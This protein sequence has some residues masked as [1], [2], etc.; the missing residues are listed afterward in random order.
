[1]EWST[2]Q[3][4]LLSHGVRILIIILVSAV[5]YIVLRRLIPLA[6]KHLMKMKGEK[7]DESLEKRTKTLSGIFTASGLLVIIA[8]AAF[9]ILAEVGINIAPYLAAAGI[10]GVA[11]GFGA[12]TLVKDLI[13]GIFIIVEDQYNVGDVVQIAGI[14]GIVQEI[15]LRRTVLRDLDGIVHFVPNGE[16]GIASNYTREWSRVN[17][18]ISVAYDTDLDHA[19]TVINRVC[20][21]MAAEPYW[22]EIILKTPEVLR[23]DNLGDSGIDIKILG[24][25]KPIRQWETMGEIRKRIKKAFDEEGI[26]IPW[27]HTKVYF[28]QTE[29]PHSLTDALAPPRPDF[30]V[31]PPDDEEGE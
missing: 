1:M 26:E 21:E 24:D 20:A 17:L 3:D 22:K 2:V 31:L 16:S 13:G 18:N 15:N 25:T 29:L 10:L 12:Q 5:L 11:L 23:I 27:P 4:W 28:G 30:H 6:M 7:S 9:M 19:I 14:S 8:S